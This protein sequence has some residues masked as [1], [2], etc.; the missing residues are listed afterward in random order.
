MANIKFDAQEQA[1]L[2]KNF[3]D[4]TDAVQG[5][6]RQLVNAVDALEGYQSKHKA[7]LQVK[8]DEVKAV[9][10]KSMAVVE[11]EQAIVKA[12]RKYLIDS[13]A[14]N[15]FAKIDVEAPTTTVADVC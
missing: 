13:E 1:I 9:I 2:I 12:K 4:G 8:I 15:P 11:E 7:Q 5:L 10:K 6:V 3:E 14:E